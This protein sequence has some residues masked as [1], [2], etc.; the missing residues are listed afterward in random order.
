MN[1]DKAREA[2]E[3][4]ENALNAECD[5]VYANAKLHSTKV[6]NAILATRLYASRVRQ[7]LFAADGPEAPAVEEAR[8]EF[9]EVESYTGVLAGVYE[10][11]AEISLS[12][13]SLQSLL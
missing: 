3:E 12:I 4:L 2:A 13:A 9:R 10:R 6:A 7:F 1:L 8:R 11:N 5:R